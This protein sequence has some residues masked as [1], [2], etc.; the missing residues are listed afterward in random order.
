M[1]KGSFPKHRMLNRLKTMMENDWLLF[2][3]MAEIHEIYLL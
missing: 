3:N 1:E 2:P